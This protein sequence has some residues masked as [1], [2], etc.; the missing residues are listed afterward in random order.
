MT[1]TIILNVIPTYSIKCYSVTQQFNYFQFN[2]F[3]R[4][5]VS[6]L[7]TPRAT[8]VPGYNNFVEPQNDSAEFL[9][10]NDLDIIDDDGSEQGSGTDFSD[11]A[12]P[13]AYVKVVNGKRL[14]VR[15]V[16]EGWS[17]N[18][19]STVQC[20]HMK[21]KATCTLCNRPKGRYGREFKEKQ[22][23]IEMK[24][25]EKKQKRVRFA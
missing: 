18:V 14:H 21:D 10:D 2:D 20:K 7:G 23:E 22:D 12:M 9:D 16:K 19:S 24:M 15:Q 4:F 17:H 13:P 25:E 5:S 6:S 3:S 8:P 1:L 11:M